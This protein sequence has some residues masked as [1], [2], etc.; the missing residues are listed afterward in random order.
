[1][2]IDLTGAQWFK[3]SYSGAQNDCVEIAWLASGYVGVRDSKHPTG[4]AIVFTSNEWNAFTLGINSGDF[5][6]PS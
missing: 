3:S 1:M 2:T 5:N 4:P 6:S